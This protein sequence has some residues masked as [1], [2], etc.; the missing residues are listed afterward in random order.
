MKQNKRIIEVLKKELK[1]VTIALIIF[2]IIFKIVF[3]KES[4]LI[5]IKSVLAFFLTFTIPGLMITI[6]WRKKLEFFERF[7]VG[8]LIGV[9]SVG[10]L[11]Y[12]LS[13]FLNI[14]INYIRIISPIVI[15]VFF[16]ILVNY[17]ERKKEILPNTSK[18]L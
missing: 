16:F 14:H 12:N 11:A 7:I 13:S 2:I 17:S 18:T 5:I 1:S 15:L 3:L 8:N 10:I 6:S 4:F 9:I